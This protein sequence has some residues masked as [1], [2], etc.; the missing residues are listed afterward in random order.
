MALSP[1]GEIDVVIGKNLSFP[2]DTQT[3]IQAVVQAEH[4]ERRSPKDSPQGQIFFSETHDEVLLAHYC[5][6]FID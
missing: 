5:I 4:I 1:C 6:P 3:Q 2:I